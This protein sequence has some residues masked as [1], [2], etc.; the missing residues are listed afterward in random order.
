MQKL[1]LFA[2]L[3]LG[4]AFTSCGSFGEGLLAGLADAR[5][6]SGYGGGYGG[7]GF[8]SMPSTTGGNMK[9]SSNPSTST[10]NRSSTSTSTNTRCKKLGASDMAHCEGTGVCQRC[11][12]KK[13]YYTTELGIARW[14]DPCTT[15]GGTGK[16][17]GCNGT[18][19]K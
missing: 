14:V 13:R 1:F 18:G 2:S 17:P 8:T 9:S 5:S 10:V 16:C 15:C 6:Y 4:M 3:S 12:G 7:V 11:N 19:H